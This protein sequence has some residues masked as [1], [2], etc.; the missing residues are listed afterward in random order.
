MK[1]VILKTIIRK[2][3]SFFCTPSQKGSDLKKHPSAY[4]HVEVRV[5][6]RP[7]VLDGPFRLIVSDH[8]WLWQQLGCQV[9][10]KAWNTQM[11]DEYIGVE[12][13][14]RLG[15]LEFR[16]YLKIPKEYGDKIPLDCMLPLATEEC[17]LIFPHDNKI[18]S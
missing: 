2:Y 12:S 11:P 7:S 10:P 18:H 14:Y 1:P 15:I 16:R 13:L 3:K 17:S 5:E 8:V 6:I 9:W 4:S